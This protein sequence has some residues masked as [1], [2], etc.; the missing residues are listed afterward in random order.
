MSSERPPFCSFC[1]VEE[2]KERKLFKGGARRIAI[3]PECVVLMYEALERSGRLP[4]SQI[5]K[6]YDA[7]TVK[8]EE[9]AENGMTLDG[10]F[11]KYDLDRFSRDSSATRLISREYSVKHELIVLNHAN[12][13]LLVAMV[14]PSRDDVLDELERM[15]GCLVQVCKADREQILRL[16]GEEYD[17]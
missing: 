4:P 10:R 7:G 6:F 3:C 2:S 5:A 17:E 8:L 15:T 16:L 11:W 12:H 1:G 13:F 14:D 9:L